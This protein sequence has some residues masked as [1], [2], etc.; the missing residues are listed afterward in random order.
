MQISVMTL[1]YNFLRNVQPCK[2]SGSF[3]IYQSML[4]AVEI[5]YSR[6]SPSLVWCVDSLRRFQ[7]FFA[8]SPNRIRANPNGDIINNI[9]PN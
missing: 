2:E 1:V 7:K 8:V 5:I 4:V 9:D 6:L 3:S